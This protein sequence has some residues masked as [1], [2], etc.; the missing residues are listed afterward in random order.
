MEWIIVYELRDGSTEE[1]VLSSEEE[2]QVERAH[3]ER[4]MQAKGTQ[5]VGYHFEQ[6]EEQSK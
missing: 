2:E 1:F 3:A 5:V 4:E 6:R